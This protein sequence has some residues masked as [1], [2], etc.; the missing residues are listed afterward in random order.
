MLTL[1]V[2]EEVKVSMQDAEHRQKQEQGPS[3]ALASLV[4][5]FLWFKMFSP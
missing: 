2:K 1:V 5:F 4:V 3:R